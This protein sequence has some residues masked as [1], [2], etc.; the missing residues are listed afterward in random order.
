MHRETAKRWFLPH[1]TAYMAATLAGIALTFTLRP[2]L[3]FPVFAALLAW[4][5][6]M[7]LH[8]WVVI[9]PAAPRDQDGSGGDPR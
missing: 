7:A 2:D 9:M 8:G 1:L 6:G 4:G 5:L 3:G